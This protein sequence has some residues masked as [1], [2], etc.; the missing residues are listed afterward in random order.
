MPAFTL[1]LQ[2]D[3]R[4]EAGSTYTRQIVSYMSPPDEFIMGTI[5]RVP[6]VGV[7]NFLAYVPASLAGASVQASPLSADEAYYLVDVDD[8]AEADVYTL[9]TVVYLSNT[10][11]DFTGTWTI[12][13]AATFED[14]SAYTDVNCQIR[15]KAE[16]TSTLILEFNLA[17]SEVVFDA[18]N[19][20][21]TLLKDI[22][23]TTSH[24][25]F[26]YDIKLIGAALNIRRFCEGKVDITAAVTYDA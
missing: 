17:D 13:S 14:L 18:V 21:V 22:P 23:E 8:H 11:E 4:I 19:G 5:L 16:S 7:Y 26:L 6:S 12:E 2:G 9:G 10:A 20:S 25:T 3:Y 1:N 24:G 15:K